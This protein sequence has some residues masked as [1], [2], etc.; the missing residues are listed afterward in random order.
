M[1][2]PYAEI[3]EGL[4]EP[5]VRVEFRSRERWIETEAYVDSGASFSI[6]KP[7]IAEMLKISY[8]RGR[9]VS[10]TVGNGEGLP[11][12]LNNLSVRFA[13]R[14]FN[15]RIGFSDKLGVD[16]NLLGRS[17]FFE[18][19]MICFNDKHRYLGITWLDA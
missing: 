14:V 1:R 13:G 12:Y 5:V 15:A 18:K 6:F 4:F 2:I 7:E 9:K 11:I 17:G 8:L 10:L 19:F 3:E 16:F